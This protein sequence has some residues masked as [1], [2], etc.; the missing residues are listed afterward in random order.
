MTVQPVAFLSI[1]GMALTL[2][3]SA[4]L[5]I[6]LFIYCRRHYEVRTS[7]LIF[8]L[9]VYYLAAR[10]LEPY[11][12]AAILSNV[13]GAMMKNMFIYAVYVAI[14]AAVVEE[15]LRLV[16]L[17]SL[18]KNVDEANAFYFGVGFCALEAIL[19]AAWPQVSN[20]LNSILINNGMMGRTLELL[21]EPDLSA[22]YFAIA[23]L[24][25]T[26]SL[27]FLLAGIERACI[28]AMHLCLSLILFYYIKLGDKK[29]I[30]L[31]I[32]GH[33]MVVFCSALLGQMDQALFSVVTTAAVTAVLVIFARRGHE[34]YLVHCAP[35]AVIVEAPAEEVSIE[36]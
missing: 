36:E 10:I 12:N 24:W 23:P 21:Q 30:A 26:S 32:V 3:I 8:G 13:G 19:I 4:G 2:I 1:F 9:I 25:E 35:A 29:Y 5:P 31:A 15:V 7:A 20:I 28:I 17:K 34:E 14:I 33:F 11:I 22:T 27:A 18:V 16:T 6:A